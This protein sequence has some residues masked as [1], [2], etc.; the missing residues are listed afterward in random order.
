[1]FSRARANNSD[2]GSENMPSRSIEILR[3]TRIPRASGRTGFASERS[4]EFKDRIMCVRTYVEREINRKYTHVYRMY[5]RR[6]EYRKLHA[7]AKPQLYKA[8]EKSDK[9]RNNDKHFAR[10]CLEFPDIKCTEFRDIAVRSSEGG[11]RRKISAEIFNIKKK[12]KK[13]R[14]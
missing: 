9:Y 1:M 6:N 3:M 2:P 8:H 11:E 12:K 10:E 14:R 5:I 7:R 13:Y 4:I